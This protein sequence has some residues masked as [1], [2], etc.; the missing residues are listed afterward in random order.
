MCLDDKLMLELQSIGLHPERVPDLAEGEE[1]EILKE[2]HELK[3]GLYQKARKKKVKLSKI[4]KALLKERE[5]ERREI[6][7]IALN[8]L[9]EMAYKRR[10]ACRGGNYSR[11]GVSRVTKVAALAFVKRT[12]ARCRKF[13]ATGKSCFSEP[14][15]Q[16]VILSASI[17]SNDGEPVDTVSTEPA[18]NVP[19]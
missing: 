4:D 18:A 9:V 5:V 17:C 14:A 1:E 12:N 16:K 19:S 8:K 13:E 6:E 11:S 7:Q 10:M 15:L 2:I 3:K